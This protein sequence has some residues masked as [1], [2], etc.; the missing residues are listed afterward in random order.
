MTAIRYTASSSFTVPTGVSIVYVSMVGGGEGGAN[1]SPS[2][3]TYGNNGQGGGSAIRVPFPCAAGNV[4]SILVGAGGTAVPTDGAW[5]NIGTMSQISIGSRNIQATGGHGSSQQIGGSFQYYDP[6]FNTPNFGFGG[7][8]STQSATTSA[9]NYG[10]AFTGQG[11]G[12]N[13]WLGAGGVGYPSSGSRS[14]AA[15]TGGGGGGGGGV[16]IAGPGNGGSGCVII[17]Y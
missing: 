6:T 3:F 7:A 15:N 4:I 12:G 5:G 8:P 16:P 11:G 17:E 14:A 10:R 9:E 1:P 13:S 2:G